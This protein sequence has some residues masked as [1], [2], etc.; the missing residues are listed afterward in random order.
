[1]ISK[2]KALDIVADYLGNQNIYELTFVDPDLTLIYNSNKLPKKVW[3]IH[4]YNTK[5]LKIGV[6]RMIGINKENSEICYDGSD[7]GE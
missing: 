1:M 5:E 3:Y 6:G 2:D 4:V 7:G